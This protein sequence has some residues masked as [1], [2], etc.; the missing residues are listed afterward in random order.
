MFL[1]TDN[2]SL[3]PS[4]TLYLRH[5]AQELRRITGQEVVPV[6][7]LHSYKI[8]AEQL[9]GTPAPAFKTFLKST[10][11]KHITI[12][13][14]FIGPSGALTDY[15]PKAIHEVLTERPDL[16]V[17]VLPHLA[18][19]V[20]TLH[21]LAQCMAAQI[22][23]TIHHF[24]LRQPAVALVDH[25]TP[26]TD[27]NA[28]RNKLA[29]LLSEILADEISVLHPCSMERR[30]GDAYAF[31]D[32]LLEHL[33][34]SQGFQRDTVLSMLFLQPGRH[35]GA[36]GDIDTIC[37][38][39]KRQHPSLQTFKTLLLLESPALIQHLAERITDT[40]SGTLVE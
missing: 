9:G 18:H 36:D 13:P 8:P 5:V 14:L 29:T 35:A 38:D 25:G 24:E 1:L 30:A 11:A 31:N 34:G 7:L 37:A 39:L 10:P 6:S 19:S 26:S 28:I 27:V 12:L 2:G 20:T 3:R 16:T 32:P 15:L 40:A 4:A 21:L 22:R 17:Q 33:L 23:H